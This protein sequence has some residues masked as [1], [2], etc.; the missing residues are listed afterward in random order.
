MLTAWLGLGPL[1]E[2]KK[3]HTDHSEVRRL[4]RE[5]RLEFR[6]TSREQLAAIDGAA[7]LMAKEREPVLGEGDEPAV[8]T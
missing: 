1:C 7:E 8:V 6:K 4:A 5:E 3:D 2:A